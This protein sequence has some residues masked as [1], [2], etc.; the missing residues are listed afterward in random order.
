[1]P[2]HIYIYNA[3]STFAVLLF[4]QD[5]EV[6][7]DLGI[8]EGL[9]CIMGEADPMVMVMVMVIVYDSI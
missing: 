3:L 9:F 2:T 7:L 1:M 6:L 8:V 5:T 4:S